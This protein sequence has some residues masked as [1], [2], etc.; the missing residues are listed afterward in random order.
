MN[1]FNRPLMKFLF[2]AT[3]L[4]LTV[5]LGQIS[6]QVSFAEVTE[7]RGIA[8][9]AVEPGFGGGVSAFDFDEDGD[10]DLF[11][12]QRFN[13]PDRLYINDGS[14][15]FTDAGGASGV[16]IMASSR[17]ALWFDYDDDHL[18]DLL[19]ASDCFNSE[20]PDCTDATSIRLYRQDTPGHF[21][22]V[23]NETGLSNAGIE[24]FFGHRAG[25]SAGD[26]DNDGD[27]DLIFGQWT[28]ELQLF[29]NHEG[30]FANESN[31]RGITNPVAPSPTDPWQSVMCDFNGDGWLDIFTSVD[32]APNHL[33]I[34]QGDGFFVDE[35]ESSGTNFSFNDMGVTLGDYDNDGDFDIFV[36]NIFENNKHN[37]LLRNDSKNGV[38]QFRELAGKVGVDDAGFGWG[39]TFFDA[40]NDT[41]LDL[42][43]TNGWFNGVGFQ[44][45]SR[46]FLQR[47]QVP[48]TFEDVT[49]TSGFEDDFYGSCLISADLNRD[50]DLDLLQVCNPSLFEGPFRI[51]ENQLNETAP[52]NW[53][54]IRPRQADKNHWCFGAVVTVEIGDLSMTRP[55]ISSTSIHGQQPAE[56]YFGL[57]DAQ[58]ADRVIVTWPFG[59]QS[60]WEN[61]SGNQVFDSSDADFNLDGN[62]SLLDIGAFVQ[63]FGPCDQD[64]QADLNHDGVVDLLDADL[65]VDSLLQR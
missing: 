27:T 6:A 29:I 63:Q 48:G 22:D 47:T 49:T 33:W 23:T 39:C 62:I 24:T 38:A 59:D 8:P 28:G 57:G 18:V 12:P 15:N 35:G 56:A 52:T 19:L 25:I 50:G 37:L 16:D 20:N 34:N 30:V 31:A 42:A 46:V 9:N 26:I 53:L 51:L 61:V 65:F 36:T 13:S 43:V 32:F 3:A 10:I 11:L 44:D 2:L 4:Q 64:C 1:D 60:V 55:I 54:A 5:A 58:A 17:S 41:L 45:Q 40:N 14:G 7:D 21:S